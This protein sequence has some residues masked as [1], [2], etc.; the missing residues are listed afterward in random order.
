[1]LIKILW[2]NYFITM[3]AIKQIFSKKHKTKAMVFQDFILNT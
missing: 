2:M 3:A 1:M